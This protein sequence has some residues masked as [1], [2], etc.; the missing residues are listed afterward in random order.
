MALY[1]LKFRPITKPKVWGA[2]TWALSGYGEDESVVANGFL[3]DNSLSEVQEIYMDELVGGKVYDRFGNVFP[4]LFKFIDAKDDLSIQVHPTDQMAAEE[5]QLGKTEMWYVTEA[6]E[7]ASVIMGF[8]RSTTAQEVRQRLQD[9][10][11]MDILQVVP[12]AKGDV[13]YIPAGT[14]HALR[15]GTQVA[16]IQETSD[17]TYRLYDYH[18]PGVDGKLRPL[19]I[20]ESIRAL[21][22]SALAA[23]LVD[24]THKEGLTTLVRDTHFITNL[25][26]LSHKVSRDYAQLDSFVVYMCVQGEVTIHCQDEESADVTIHQGETVLLPAVLKDIVLTPRK[27]AQILEVFV[28]IA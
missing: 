10:S 7:D 15:K 3:K 18:R 9:D 12:V 1:P 19:H 2:E 28:E 26:T 4:L 8:G 5:G 14:V 24:Y 20:E 23:P 11:I 27:E 16:E 13:A 6:A 22:Y 21:D 25:L 17:L